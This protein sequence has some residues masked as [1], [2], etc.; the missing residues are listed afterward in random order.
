MDVLHDCCCGLDVHKRS[1]SACLILP[2]PTGGWTKEHRTFGCMTND[3]LQMCDWLEAAGCTH[4]AMESTGVYWKPFY[5]LMED[6]FTVLVVNA[7]HIKAVPGRKTDTRD[8]EWIADLLQHGLVRGSA[9]PSRAQR[10]VRDLTRHRTTLVQDRVRVVNRLEKVLE[11]TNIKLSSVVSSLTGVSAHAMLV[12]L[13]GGENDPAKL[14][15]LAKGRLREKRAELEAAL[16]GIVRPHHRFMIVEHLGQ[17]DY[18]DEAIE[19][20]SAQIA[21]HLRPFEHELALLDSI[22]GVNRY[23]AET[24]LAEWGMQI[25][26]YPSADHLSA[27]AGI[28]PGNNES[29]GKRKS[30][31][32]RKGNPW[33]KAMLVE[34]AHGASHAKKTYLCAQYRR[35]ASR[36]GKKRALVAVG[37][38]ILVIAYHMLKRKTGYVDIGSNYFDERQITVVT[39]HLVR[40]LERLGFEV[41]LTQREAA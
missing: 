9:I 21:E 25:D 39:K 10:T 35:L 16:V 2:H 5:N 15:Q 18:Y 3:I 34:A 24:L 28:C 23:G 30:G 38:S 26:R 19:R 41:S 7:H 22:P 31:K 20:V 11:D 29:G 40:R 13:V 12:A 37:H 32:I 36:R 6:R 17:I 8:A 1:V 27:W 4:V 33:L 14:S